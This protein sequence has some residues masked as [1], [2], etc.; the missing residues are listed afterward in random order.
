MS[1]KVSVESS[2]RQ[3]LKSFKK[4]PQAEKEIKEGVLQILDNPMAGEYLRGNLS[5]IRKISIGRRPEYRIM[6]RLYQC[7]NPDKD[8]CEVCIV[9]TD[10]EIPAEEC[11]GLIQFV[12][13][14]TREECNNLYGLS[15]KY[16]DGTLMDDMTTI[17]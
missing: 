13:V 14:K 9:K 5:G 10:D 8:N 6:Y 11:M 1:Y 4:N 3:D 15:K 2:F 7:C 16:F 17:Q 12:F